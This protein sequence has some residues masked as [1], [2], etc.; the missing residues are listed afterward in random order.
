MQLSDNTLIGILI[1]LYLHRSGRVTLSQLAVG[2]KLRRKNVATVLSDLLLSN[3]VT[4]Y[5][6]TKGRGEYEVVGD[7]TVGQVMLALKEP[8]NLVASRT[9]RALLHGQTER[10]SLAAFIK[11]FQKV[12]ISLYN[13]KI[14]N[15]GLELVANEMALLDKAGY[16]N[17]IN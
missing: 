12:H 9:L 17:E 16:S 1:I 4:V 6:I 7:P 10:R 15:L 5:P 2:L 13:R 14:K 3:L 11:N 8:V